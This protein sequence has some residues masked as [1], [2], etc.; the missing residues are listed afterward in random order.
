MRGGNPKFFHKYKL[1]LSKE[2]VFVADGT[3]VLITGHS[4]IS[5][6]DKYFVYDILYIFDLLL[7]LLSVACVP[8]DLNCA[9]TFFLD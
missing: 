2:K 9:L 6:M 8:K 3:K 1:I 5:L 7:N 4:S